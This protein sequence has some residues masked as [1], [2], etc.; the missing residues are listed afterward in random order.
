MKNGQKNFDTINEQSKSQLLVLSEIKEI[1]TTLQ[2]PFWMRGGWAI[3][4]LL[5]RIT[6]RHNDIDLVAW[7]YRRKEIERALVEAGYEL[8][9]VS[10]LQTDFCKNGIDVQFCFLNRNDDGQIIGNGIPDWIWR[11]DALP[12]QLFELYGLSVCVMSPHQLLEEKEVYEQIGRTPRVKD[13]ES[14]KLL[15]KIIDDLVK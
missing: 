5:G 6:R 4:F 3:D 12:T 2:E 9:P 14:K 1:F 10:E 7:A 15:R 11:E 8:K 13:V